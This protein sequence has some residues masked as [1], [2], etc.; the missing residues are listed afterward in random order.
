[1]R[2][3]GQDCERGTFS[4]RHSVLIDQETEARHTSLNHIREGQARYEVINSMLSEEAVLGFE[5]GYSLVGAQCADMLG[6]AVRR[7]RQRRAGAC[8]TSSSRRASASGCACRASSASCHT[9]M[10]ARARSIPRPASNASCRCAPRTTCRWR[11]ARHRLEL[12]PH[13]AP[14]AQ[15]RV[16]QA[17]GADDAEVAAAPQALRV[18]SEADI[19]EGSTFH[20]VLRDDAETRKG[21]AIKARQGCQ[22]PA[23]GVVFGQGLLRS[24][25]RIARSAASTMS[26]CCASSSFIRSR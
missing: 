2:L 17:A 8:S 6:G 1:V 19:A 5:Y 10:R 26:T 4:S 12:L 9:A 21:E 22:D 16:P 20:R 15:A 11:T 23:R 18:R 24:L 25:T 3:S 7:L 14:A 13:P